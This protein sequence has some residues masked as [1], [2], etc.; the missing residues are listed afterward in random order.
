VKTRACALTRERLNVW[1][2]PEEVL[3]P[4][5]PKMG[6][7]S[8]E[9]VDNYKYSGDNINSNHDMHSEINYIAY[10][11]MKTIAITVLISYS[12]PNYRRK[13]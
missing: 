3:D 4:C 12:S 9:N 1:S 7:C 10:K 13:N 11:K 2:Y 5:K 6:I 8:L